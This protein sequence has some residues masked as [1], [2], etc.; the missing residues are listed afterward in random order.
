MRNTTI[1]ISHH[2][3]GI[4]ALIQIH[5][6]E[7]GLLALSVVQA[8]LEAAFPYI[9][10]YDSARIIDLVIEGNFP[11]AG[12]NIALLAILICIAGLGLDAGNG[13]HA[14]LSN[15]A[16]RNMLRR[17]SQKAMEL[18]YEEMEDTGLLHQISDAFY[19][20][21]HVGGY[22]AFISYYQQLCKNLIQIAISVGA[23]LHLSMLPTPEG[24]TGWFAWVASPAVSLGILALVTVGN[25]LFSQTVAVRFQRYSSSGYQKK[26][27]VERTLNYFSDKVFM[28]REMGKEIRLFHMLELILKKHGKALEHSIRFYNR[29]YDDAAKNQETLYLSSQG[30]CTLAAYFVVICKVLSGA[31]SVGELSQYIGT[32]VLF[33]QALRTCVAVNQKIALQTEFITTFQ[34]FM[35]VKSKKASGGIPIPKTP[36]QSYCIEFHHV[37]YRYPG[38]EV[39]AL[40]DISCR[41]TSRTKA[42]VVGKNG[43]GKTT[44]VKLLCRLYEPTEGKITL[45]GV[46]I[47]NY[48]YEDYLSLFSVVFQDFSLF[49]FPMGE[50]IAA[51]KPMHEPQIW[52]CLAKAG[53]WE[54]VR[55][56]PQQLHTNLYRLDEDGCNVSGGEAQKIAIARALYRDAPFIILDEPTAAL[57]PESEYEIFSAFDR[58]VQDKGSVF[59]SHR[60]GSCR[61]CHEILVLD[62]GRLAEHGSH[63]DLMQ[64][65]GPYRE[66]Y[67]AQ[68]NCYTQ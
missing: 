14:Y 63:E 57:D 26:I 20:M 38:T 47:R 15:R 2:R 18:D 17:I 31:V 16:Q 44:F 22:H 52:D 48:C 37:S 60:M 13:L 24:N 55:Q 35:Q 36:G 65:N 32:I 42:A 19:T 61:S 21:N 54:R 30:L 33:H 28:N 9:E 6:T 12:R 23:V 56:M 45:N 29:Y 3:C 5:Q 40:K 41:I 4:R 68:A 39:D 8:L 66:L 59:I 1:P 62:H 34:N 53:L 7:R 64:E 46:D 50:N 11:A 51:G 25:F 10:L 67:D 58:L 43:A 27:K 49:S